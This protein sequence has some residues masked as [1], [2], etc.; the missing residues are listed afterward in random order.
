[1][2]NNEAHGRLPDS[3][4]YKT[5]SDLIRLGKLKDGGYLVSRKD[6]DKTDFLI[7][8]GMGYDWSFEADFL[9]IRPVPLRMFD[10]SVRPRSF[11]KDAYLALVQLKFRRFYLGL[12]AL[13]RYVLFFRGP[14]A[15]FPVFIGNT[16]SKN[17]VTIS[18][19]LEDTRAKNV[20]LK[21][22]IEGGEYR[23]L[24]TLIAI[25]EKISGM[26][27]EFHDCDLHLS[28]I[29]DFVKS[30]PLKVVHIH[31]NNYGA[32]EPSTNLPLVLE[33]TFSRNSDTH[34][35]ALLPHPL[36]QPNNPKAPDLYLTF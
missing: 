28:R 9:K 32:V 10:G 25:S 26:A 23:I 8:L 5:A 7:G 20:F 21:I 22:D 15:H 35:E 4:R 27:V 11:L 19:V 16:A 33:I 13:A 6:V 14:K 31:A 1:M 24:N 3:L 12:M 2:S 18:Q 34:D 36:D 30:F 29:E 17:Q